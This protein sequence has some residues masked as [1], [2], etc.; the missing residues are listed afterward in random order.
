MPNI[1]ITVN[2]DFTPVT[3]KNGQWSGQPTWTVTPSNAQAQQGNNKV[4]WS[5]TTLN[6][7]SQNSVPSGYSASFTGDGIVFKSTNQQAW[8]DPPALQTDGTITAD[9]NFQGLSANVYYYY[10]TK[11][12]LKPNAG[13]TGPTGTF[14]ADPDVE[15]EMGNAVVKAAAK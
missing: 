10:T 11:V 9:D 8:D 2:V 4:T 5:L 3:I 7:S 13:T 6:S 14:T 15:N 1:P 12:Q